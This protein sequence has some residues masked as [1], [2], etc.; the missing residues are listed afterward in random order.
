M[1]SPAQNNRLTIAGKGRSSGFL[2][3]RKVCAAILNQKLDYLKMNYL[4][5]IESNQSTVESP[6][7]CFK[8]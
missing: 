8:W 1:W 2:Y 5:V 4:F 3:C 7:N 6:K